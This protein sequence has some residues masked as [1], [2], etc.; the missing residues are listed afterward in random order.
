M[1][2]FLSL[3]AVGY[4]DALGRMA[5]RTEA[6]QQEK[7][8][9]L[10]R[11][12]RQTVAALQDAAPKRSGDF[13]KGI[14]FRTDV[15]GRETRLTFYV[16]GPH[17]FLLDY[18]RKGTRP[19]EIPTGGAAAQRAKGYPLRFY[20]P[21]GPHGPDIYYYWRVWHPGTKPNDFVQ[22]VLDQQAAAYRY[23]IARTA[24]QVAW[25]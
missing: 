16:G 20:W 13:A 2:K 5:A 6:L 19:H 23:E 14:G 12:G 10:R 9:T 3:E 7:R 18:I 8:E 17:A 1:A 15:R 11:I 22:R 21:K 4:R 24:Q 25:L